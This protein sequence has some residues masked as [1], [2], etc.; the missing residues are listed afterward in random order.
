MLTGAGASAALADAALADLFHP[1]AGRRGVVLAVSGGGDSTALLV[2]YARWR[3]LSRATPPAVV[4][5]VD[6]GLR[7]DSADEAKAVAALAGRLGLDHATLPWAGEKPVGD[8]AAAARTARYRLLGAFARARGCD[9]VAT[10]HTEDDQAE[11]LLLR[12][13]RASGVDGLAAMRPARPLDA[14][15][16]VLLARPLLQVSRAALRATLRDAGIAWVEDP[17]NTDPR[18]GRARMRALLPLLAAEGMTAGRLA[19]SAR[20]AA[21]AVDALEAATDALAASALHHRADG[22]IEIDRAALAAAPDEIGLRLL[23]R[24]VAAVGTPPPHGPRL[25]RLEAAFEAV[26]AAGPDVRRTLA[27][28]VI[29]R[30]GDRIRL[31][32]APSRRPTATIVRADQENHRSPRAWQDTP[33]DLSLPADA[34][35]RV[36][37]LGSAAPREPK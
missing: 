20:R 10:A 6:H 37:G 3:T 2:L 33:A 15:G 35:V 25:D 31:H 13:A 34:A 11:T 30:R 23:G 14:D 36:T 17:S 16:D 26:A 29:D 27:G 4:A 21:R 18:H 8:L 22:S 9:T 7:P 12:L 1:L 19:A 32:R 24:A 28:A 5:T